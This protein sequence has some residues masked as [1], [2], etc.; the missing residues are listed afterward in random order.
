MINAGGYAQAEYQKKY[1][2]KLIGNLRN[3]VMRYI[4]TEHCNTA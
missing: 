1:D 2:H 4:T 3:L